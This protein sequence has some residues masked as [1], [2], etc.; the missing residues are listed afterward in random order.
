[1][2]WLDEEWDGEVKEE[3]RKTE[4]SKP[5]TKKLK[6]EPLVEWGQATK[7]PCVR[8]WLLGCTELE[9]EEDSSKD[10]RQT[11][12]S[13]SQIPSAKLKQ[14]ELDFGQG[15]RKESP[16]TE[17][18]WKLGKAKTGKL[19]KKEMKDLASKNQ[20]ICWKAGDGMVTEVEEQ[21]GG[22]D[23]GGASIEPALA[24]QPEQTVLAE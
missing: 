15:V 10:W 23:D 5:G 8:S 22:E 14:M 12:P 1:M 18:K 19:S 4:G 11:L 2:E 16:C 3:K 17:V 20:K 13:P 24:P 21:A 6:L 7:A 9:E